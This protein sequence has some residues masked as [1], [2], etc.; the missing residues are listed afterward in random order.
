MPAGSEA[1][2]LVGIAQVRPAL[3]ILALKPG[4]IDQH[5]LWGWPACERRDT[6]AWMCLYGTGHGFT[7]QM[8]VAYSAI[9]RSLEN[10]PEPATF[11]MAFRAQASGSAYNSPRR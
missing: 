8:S 2:H 5:L 1:D 7:S 11:K 3:K 6:R 4:Q 9:V 10:F